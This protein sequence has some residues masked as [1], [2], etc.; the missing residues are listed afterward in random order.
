LEAHRLGRAIDRP[1]RTHSVPLEQED[2]DE[3]ER[4]FAIAVKWRALEMH[5][6]YDAFFL[7]QIFWSRYALF[8]MDGPSYT[9]PGHATS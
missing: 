7:R 4:I 5:N 2:V 3:R 1:A 8:P 9:F 6:F